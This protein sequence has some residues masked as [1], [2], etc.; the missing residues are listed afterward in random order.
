MAETYQRPRAHKMSDEIPQAQRHGISMQGGSKDGGGDQ[1][2]GG[3]QTVR[4]NTRKSRGT[5]GGRANSHEQAE[6]SSRFHVFQ[7]V[8]EKIEEMS[9]DTG[10]LPGPVETHNAEGSRIS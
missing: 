7:E 8:C 3:W 10:Y 2:N 1:S 4:G 6:S 9:I 5:D